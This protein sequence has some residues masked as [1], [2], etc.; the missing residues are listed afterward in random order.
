MAKSFTY[1]DADGYEIVA[2]LPTNRVVCPGC[3]G[4]GTR[5][6]RNI[7]EHAYSA[8]EFA[9]A[10]DEDEA[11]EYFRRGGIY[12]VVCDECHGDRVV[13]EVD[14]DRLE[15]EQPAVFEAWCDDLRDRAADRATRAAELRMG[16]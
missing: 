5:L 15:K 3:D 1:E 10:F 7:G 2:E 16:C 6:N 11:R 12:D 4:Y 8:E 9:E 13:D 14:A